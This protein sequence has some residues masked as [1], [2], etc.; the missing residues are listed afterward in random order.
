MPM[1]Q[2]ISELQPGSRFDSFLVVTEAN[3]LAEYDKRT[4]TKLHDVA[5]KRADG[6]VLLLL[7]EVTT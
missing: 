1:S 6:E 4:D 2:R 5:L 3:A 7:R